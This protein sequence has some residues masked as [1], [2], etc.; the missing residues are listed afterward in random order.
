MVQQIRDK[1]KKDSFSDRLNKSQSTNDFIKGLWKE[2]PVFVQVLGMCPVLAVTNTSSN[3]LAMGLATSFVLL[4]SNILISLLRNFIPKQVRISSYIL[5]IAT[6]VTVTDYVI[7]AI[8]V[9]LHKSL[10]AFISLI[11]VNCLILSRAEAFAS[12]NTVGRSVLDALGMGLGFT[13]GLLCLGVVREL[14]GSRSI[15][16]IEIFAEGFQEWIVMVLPAGGF[17]TLAFWLLLFNIIKAKKS[18]S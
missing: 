17:F 6:F 12:K 11:V 15:F 2:N 8:S 4:M 14:L 18:T 3:A 10:G 16:G 5:I 13:F 1:N 7:Q 9:E